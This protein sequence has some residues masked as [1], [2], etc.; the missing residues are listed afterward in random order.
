MDMVS[1]WV[2][3]LVIGLMVL[4]VGLFIAT[5]FVVGVQVIV[6]GLAHA[7]REARKR[8]EATGRKP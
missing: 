1:L 7:W 6:G 2:G 8:D 3:R 5:S 4:V